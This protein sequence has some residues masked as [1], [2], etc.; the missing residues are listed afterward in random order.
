MQH[1]DCVIWP[2]LALLAPSHKCCLFLP[3]L[4]RWPLLRFRLGL[5]Q[6]QQSNIC[7]RCH[8]PLKRALRFI[9]RLLLRFRVCING[10]LLL[11]YQAWKIR[12]QPQQSVT[13]RWWTASC[14]CLFRADAC[15]KHRSGLWVDRRGRRQQGCDR[16]LES[17]NGWRLR[18]SSTG[19]VLRNY[20]QPI[21][22]QRDLAAREVRQDVPQGVWTHGQRVLFRC[23]FKCAHMNTRTFCYKAKVSIGSKAPRVGPRVH[24]SN[25]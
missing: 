13:T 15:R 12:Q 8:P 6:W 10:C 25:K 7:R 20:F 2:A 19:K 4:C 22:R 1:H 9:L 21:F 23:H 3:Y 14:K 24:K 11:L 5:P 18:Q 16:S 17:P